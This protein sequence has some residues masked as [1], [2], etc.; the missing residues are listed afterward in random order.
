MEKITF[1]AVI[2]TVYWQIYIHVL[3]KIGKFSVERKKRSY[4]R[5][6]YP[7][8]ICIFVK[9]GNL[10]ITFNIK[11]RK[12]QYVVSIKNWIRQTRICLHAS[13]QYPNVENGKVSQ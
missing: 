13:K 2:F 9:M 1:Y 11:S 5:L 10:K 7:F 8:V 12:F 3:Y 6:F 4:F